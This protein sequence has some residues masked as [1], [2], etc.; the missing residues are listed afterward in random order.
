M[1]MIPAI[2]AVGGDNGGRKIKVGGDRSDALIRMFAIVLIIMAGFRFQ[3]G[4]DWTNYINYFNKA[5]YI[6]IDEAIYFGMEPG[7]YLSNKL[8][9]YLEIGVIA[10]N[11]IAAALFFGGLARFCSHMQRPWLAMAVSIPYLSVVV[12]M[13]YSRQAAALGLIMYGYQALSVGRLKLFV[14]LVFAAAAFHKTAVLVLPI[15][16]LASSRGRWWS[17]LWLGVVVFVGYRVSLSSSIDSMVTSY[18]DGEMQS[19]GA[20]IRLIMNAIPALIFVIFRKKFDLNTTEERLWFWIA[21]ISLAILAALLVRPSMSTALD[22]VALYFLP[23]QVLVFSKMPNVLDRAGRSSAQM[24]TAS[25]LIYY[26]AVLAVW[27]NYAANAY[28]WLPYQI[29]FS[30]S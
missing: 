10:P 24:V 9:A 28:L 17:A 3:V 14:G 23:I 2:A 7:Y 26:C 19:S 21:L 11:L 25:I 1:Y 29:N 5:A 12:A 20:L 4:G 27:L 15:A 6:D 13:G 8:G 16:I 30:A 18:V 22:R